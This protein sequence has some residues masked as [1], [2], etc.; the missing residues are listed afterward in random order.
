MN[1]HVGI[2]VLLG[3]DNP[4]LGNGCGYYM[5]EKPLRS[6]KETMSIAC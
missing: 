3:P 1:L 4:D 5:K 2:L 6:G